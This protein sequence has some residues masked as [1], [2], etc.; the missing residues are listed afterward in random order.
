MTITYIMVLAGIPA[1]AIAFGVF[2]YWFAS[3]CLR[4]GGYRKDV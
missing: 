2:V 3:E 4:Q 1:I